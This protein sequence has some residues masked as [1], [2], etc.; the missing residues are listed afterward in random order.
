MV[1]VGT[2]R[3][4]IYILQQYIVQEKFSGTLYGVAFVVPPSPWFCPSGCHTGRIDGYRLKPPGKCFA[5]QPDVPEGIEVT[6]MFSADRGTRTAKGIDRRRQK[7]NRSQERPVQPGYWY[8]RARCRLMEA[9][10]CQ[11]ET[12]YPNRKKHQ[13]PFS[14]PPRI[15][16]A[17]EAS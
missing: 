2:A 10:K 11:G 5:G 13:R 12:V 1:K 16:L 14:L 8:S 17:R 4:K 3:S 9:V 6:I 7:I 15:L